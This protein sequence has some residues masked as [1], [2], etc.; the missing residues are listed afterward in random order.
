MLSE[1]AP[2]PA[3][4]PRACLNCGETLLGPYCWNCGQEDLDL[5]R[6]L[7]QLAR[8]ATGDLLNLDTRL[9]RTLGPLF[10]RPGFLIREY[11]TGR[12]VPY[13]PPLK[14]FLLATLIFFGLVALL[15]RAK[16]VVFRSADQEAAPPSASGQEGGLRYGFRLPP[17]TENPTWIDRR[18]DEAANRAVENPDAFG[19]AVLANM[20]RA[21][22]V[23]LP[24]F[25]LLL[26]LF[27]RRQD[28]YYLDHLIF[29]LY[30]HAFAFVL[31][32]LLVILGRAWIPGWLG[33]PLVLLLWIWFFTYL[34]IALRKVYGGTRWKTFFKLTG[35]LTTYLAAFAGMV[36]ALVLVTL[37]WF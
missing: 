7:R 31:L 27:Y 32:T 13:V 15:P 14:M 12:R 37:W 11:L 2:S 36:V 25:A 5:H 18:L 34:A 21:F 3:A 28:H 26:K 1:P 33:T 22:F 30:Y 4:E 35:L 20:P 19:E 29:A 8:E 10:F 17:P 24:L 23:L 9:L 16:V 6:P